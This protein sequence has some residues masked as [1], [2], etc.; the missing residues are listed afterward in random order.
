MKN[1]LAK[2]GRFGILIAVL[3]V[4]VLCSPQIAHFATD[5]LWFDEVGYQSVFLTFTFAK[6]AVGIVVF[7][8]V[9]LL[10]YLTL[11]VTTKYEPK[12]TVEGDTV[13][14]VPNK[15]GGKRIM[16][17]VPSL[18]LG[19]LAGYLSATALWQNILLFLQQTPAGVTDP[20]FG[21]DISFYFFSLSLFE[22]VYALAFLF[23]AVIFLFNLLMTFYLQGFSKQTFQLM[24]KRII[25]FTTAFVLL[26]IAGFQLQAANLLYAQDGAVLGAGYTDLHVTLPMYYIASAACVLTA[27][28]LLAALKKK[29]AKIAAVGPIALA[30][31]L[32]IGGLAATGVQNFIVQP[33]EIAKEQPYITNNIEMT[34]KAYGLDDIKEMEF[35]GSGTLTATDLQ[36]EMDTIKNIRLIDY[37]PT[38]T[39]F[40]QLQSM[41][42]YYK[43]VDVDIDRYDIS[44]TQQQVYLS[45][46]ELDQSSLDD[47]AQTWVNKYLKYTHGYGAVVTP[48][49]QVTSQ[50]QPEMWVENIPP[51]TTIPELEITRPEIYYGQLTND[52]VIV[53][54]EEPE[55]DYPIGDSNAQSQYEGDAGIP[56]NFVNKTLFAMDRSNYKILFSN[57]IT[58]DSKILL[59]RNILDRVEKIAPFLTF[60]S[61]PYLV[62][63]DGGLV[64]VIDAYTSTDKYPYAAK[65]TNR[66]SIFYGQNYIRNS[67]KATVNAYTGE[68]SFYIVDKTDPLVNSYAKVFPGLFKP[69]DEM[70]ENLREHLKYSTTLFE[71]QTEI[72]Q[73]YHMK[74]PT[75]FYNKEDVWS[76]A[77]EIY[78]SET[79]KMESYFVNMR[80][81]GSDELEFLLMRPFTPT[82]KQNMVSWL[83]ARNDDENYGELVLFKFPKQT[84]IYG[85]MQVEARISN[86]SEISQNLNLW[87]QQG[88]SVIRS[89]LLVV[90]IKESILYIEPIYLTMNS[91]N[92]LP[93]V[94]RIV[95][96]Y[97][98]KIVMEK[99]LDEALSKLFGTDFRTEGAVPST[100]DGD[101]DTTSTGGLLTYNE[102]VE[103]IKA[104]YQNAKRSAQNGNWADYG[105]YLEQLEQAISQL[106]KSGTSSTSSANASSESADDTTVENAN[107]NEPSSDEDI[108]V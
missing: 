50:G 86:D 107:S 92:S 72:Y 41:R 73:Q 70:P 46:R 102:V 95:V 1:L 45:A 48:V 91:E 35:S 69:L 31:V 18:V 22:T 44:G 79:T 37:R 39:V 24:G 3:A 4:L 89:N 6:F 104:A 43:F 93:E 80:L 32:V 68:T 19:V 82:Q 83:A 61:D 96:A 27:V 87:D 63:Q 11:H 7:L 98:D 71:V 34:N 29:S 62:V 5:Y 10:S 14:N 30:A 94:V 25:Y 38:I 85:P 99:T 76:I 13:V 17:L 36:E 28:C 2:L 75:V 84:T 108:T 100:P 49:N 47:S 101:N 90:P 78:G 57:L 66:E 53:N 81:P 9:F 40:N 77:N 64:W 52:Y 15:K 60:D 21:R 20:V 105:R 12:V 23:L 88:S 59:N 26:L 67:V 74:N 55:F 54:T 8:L 97:Q 56:M 65:V 42:L 106:D 58:S 51:S 16:A 103:Q 33:A